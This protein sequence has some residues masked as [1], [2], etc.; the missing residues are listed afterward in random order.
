MMAEVFSAPTYTPSSAIRDM[1]GKLERH[2]PLQNLTFD[3]RDEE[4]GVYLLFG[5]EREESGMNDAVYSP[6]P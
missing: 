1:M 3:D 5:D 6:M 2:A 4:W